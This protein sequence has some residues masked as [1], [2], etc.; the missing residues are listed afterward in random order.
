ML[1]IERLAMQLKGKDDLAAEEMLD[2]Y[3]FT[4][5]ELSEIITCC[6]SLHAGIFGGTLRQISGSIKSTIE[7]SIRIGDRLPDAIQYGDKLN[8]FQG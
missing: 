2:R 3:G 6:T 7:T 8:I 1:S 4:L 5:G